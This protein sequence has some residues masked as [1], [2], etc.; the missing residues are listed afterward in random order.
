MKKYLLLLAFTGL[1]LASVN[2]SCSSPEKKVKDAGL[3]VIQAQ[4][5]LDESNRKYDE[6]VAKYR[7]LTAENVAANYQMITDYNNRR[8]LNK[9]RVDVDKQIKIAE[10][11]MKNSEMQIKMDNYKA[12]GAE[13]W[14]S[15]KKEFDFDMDKLRNSFIGL[16]NDN[17]K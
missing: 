10:L 2:Q 13:K 5:T 17:V 12:D 8:I 14:E 3:E 7:I 15:F 11:K 16:T 4:K 9:E 1:V 6:E